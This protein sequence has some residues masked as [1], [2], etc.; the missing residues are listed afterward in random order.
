MKII[1][2]DAEATGI[3][4]EDRICQP[5]YLVVTENILQKAQF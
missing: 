3:L 2:L 4:E 5:S 1:I